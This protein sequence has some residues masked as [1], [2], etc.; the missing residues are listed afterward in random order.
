MFR[1]RTAVAFKFGTRAFNTAKTVGT[2][3]TTAIND[4]V[5][6]ADL[7]QS[8][9]SLWTL[10]GRNTTPPRLDEIHVILQPGWAV[11]GR[12]EAGYAPS[13]GS[14]HFCQYTLYSR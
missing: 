12:S 7:G 3:L 11:F 13:R 4:N 10:G 1:D 14:Y 8:A 5:R 2:T 6:N 9:R